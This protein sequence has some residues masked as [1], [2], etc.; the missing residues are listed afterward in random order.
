MVVISRKV[1]ESIFIESQEKNRR[2]VT[3][4]VVRLK[5]DG[6]V[7]L[8]VEAPHDWPILRGEIYRAILD[9]NR[10]SDS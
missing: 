2:S 1:G 4:T 9:S 8:G 10:N 6:T 3:I 7:F 5:A